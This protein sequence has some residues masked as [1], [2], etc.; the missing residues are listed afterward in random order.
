MKKL[1]LL[2]S[3][4]FCFLQIQA[5]ITPESV[6]LLN[7]PNIEADTTI[8]PSPANIAQ[9]QL[10]AYNAHDIDAF[11]AVY[12]D[13]VEIYEFPDKLMMKGKDKLYQAYKPFFE[14][15][16][17]L[18]CELVARVVQGDTVIDKEHVTGLNDGSE[19]KTIAMYKIIAGKIEKVYFLE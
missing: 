6:D 19:I 11:V 5:Q 3:L 1:L 14:S 13:S 17:D 7:N 4:I 9:A 12:A 18:H 8:Y 2:A 16:P 10:D 15:T